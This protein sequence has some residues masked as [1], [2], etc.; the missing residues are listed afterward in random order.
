METTIERHIDLNAP[1]S[2]VWQA[3]TDHGQFGEWFRVKLEGPFVAGQPTGGHITWPNWEH[4]R[5]DVDVKELTPESY[6][7]F[8]WHPYA[9]HPSHDYSHETPTLV[10]FKLVPTS[11]GTSLTVIESGFDK[12][13]AERYA[14]AFRMNSSGW[15][16]QLNNIAEYL[17]H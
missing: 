11:T 13:P 14:D 4:L 5:M 3:L 16:Q 9:I 1:Q 10:E 8:T 2:R 6:F 15:E 12:I 7:S 17:T